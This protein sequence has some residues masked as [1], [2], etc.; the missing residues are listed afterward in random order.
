MQSKPKKF[1]ARRNRRGALKSGFCGQHDPTRAGF[2]REMT[3]SLYPSRTLV[4]M[5]PSL[6][7]SHR[8]PSPFLLL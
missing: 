3:P 4:E 7:P 5:T 8:S 1:E 6:Y 2:S